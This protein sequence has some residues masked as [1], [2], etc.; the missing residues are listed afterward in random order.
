M[1][2]FVLHN[3]NVIES[4]K[5]YIDHFGDYLAVQKI[6]ES[7]FE[8]LK[9]YPIFK[10]DI[11][12]DSIYKILTDANIKEDFILINV[13]SLDYLVFKDKFIIKNNPHLILDGVLFIAKILNIKKI[14]IVLKNYYLEEKDII[15]KAIVEAEDSNFTNDTKINIYDEDSYY[16]EFNIRII[17][18]FF[19]NKKYIFDLETISQITYLAHIGGFSFKNYGSGEYKG[20]NILS[21]SGDILKPNLYEF[22]MYT[23]LR[24]VVKSIG[25]TDKNYTIKCV[26]TNGFLNPPVDFNTFQKMT[27]DYECFDSFN[28]KFGNGGLCFIQEN[29]CM[30]RV[31]LKII[32]FA[33]TI[34]CKKCMPCSYGFDLCEYY[35][36]RMLLGNSDFNDY[37]NLKEA[38][39][40]VDIGASCLYIKSLAKCISSSI[41]MF[42]D[43]FLYL[44]ENRVTLYSFIKD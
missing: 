7:F 5:S 42:S 39:E 35:I 19:E 14:D 2:K 25:G 40:M 21:V 24:N 30:I 15:I 1:K 26:F 10:R 29:R 44:I 6:N 9:N 32:Q 20:T 41:E 17:P 8:D 23:P 18:S 27:L 13:A 16:N 33:K 31:V 12:Q 22:E 36:N 43:E 28:M 34:S 11:T 38:V 4:I 37:A 3:E